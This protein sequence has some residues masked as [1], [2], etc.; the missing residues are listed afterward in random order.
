MNNVFQIAFLNPQTASLLELLHWFKTFCQ[1]RW[2]RENIF[3][4]N[5]NELR[6]VI[7]NENRSLEEFYI[8]LQY[9]GEYKKEGLFD[10]PGFDVRACFVQFEPHFFY[11][12]SKHIHKNFKPY[13]LKL[14]NRFS[15]ESQVFSAK[16]FPKAA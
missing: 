2:D 8:M 5:W 1:L 7:E 11:S 4:K 10:W 16:V 9:L 3:E 12:P 13:L 14:K 6:L 15:T